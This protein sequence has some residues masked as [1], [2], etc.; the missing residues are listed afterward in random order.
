MRHGRTRRTTLSSRLRFGPYLT[1]TPCGFLAQFLGAVEQ[2]F[3][4]RQNLVDTN[5]SFF[6]LVV[7]PRLRHGRISLPQP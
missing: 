4:S 5:G 6:F 7:S 3:C 2:R 1:A